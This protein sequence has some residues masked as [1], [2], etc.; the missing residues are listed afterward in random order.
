MRR[1]LFPMF[2]A[3]VIVVVTVAAAGAGAD[4]RE[5]DC[6]GPPAQVMRNLEY[7]EEPVSALQKLDVYGF[8]LPRGCEDVPVVVYVHGGGW[9]KGDKR[10]VGDKAS[11]FNEL[12]YVFVSVNYRLSSP[13][14]DPDRPMHPDHSDDVGASI[15]WVEE[16][17][18]D[19]GGNGAR[20]ELIG[21]SA[22]AHLV[23]L[24]GLDPKY[25]D[26][27][28]GEERSVRCVIPN[29]GSYD[30]T[31]RFEDPEGA[32]LLHNAFGEDP[33]TLS[34]ASP[35]THIGDRSQPPDFLVVRRGFFRR[36]EQQTEFIEA[37]EAGGAEVTVLDAVGLSH[38]DVNRLIGVPND[39]AMTPE[40]EQFT[41]ACLG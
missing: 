16:N 2:V 4:A 33:E 39:Q 40:I 35:I 20:I 28:G 27:A 19:Y 37:L 7:V 13:A 34:D 18:D 41:T 11:F 3:S 1:R 36:A 15:A 5:S 8:D 21:H 23:A 17:I 32:D 26:Q 9:R 31:E 12:G 10:A 30:L 22:G 14:N 24:V 6:D 25:V 38:G 29:D